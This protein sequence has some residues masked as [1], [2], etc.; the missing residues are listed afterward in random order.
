MFEPDALF[1]RTAVPLP[2]IELEGQL[3]G[4]ADWAGPGDGAQV[5]AESL[6]G[7]GCSQLVE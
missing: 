7:I 2:G 1:D 4:R 6:P 3:P 5:Y